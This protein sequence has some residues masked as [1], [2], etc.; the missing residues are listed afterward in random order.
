MWES[1][2]DFIDDRGV[3]KSF[4]LY[5]PIGKHLKSFLASLPNM[6]YTLDSLHGC[7]AVIFQ[8]YN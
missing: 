7:G 3:T 8:P 4:T 5:L 6:P 2:L 1:V